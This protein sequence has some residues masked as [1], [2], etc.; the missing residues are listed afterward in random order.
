[1]NQNLDTLP[2]P[3]Q[4]FSEIKLN[5]QISSHVDNSR[6]IIKN[7]LAGRDK[8]LLVVIG[9]CS[10]HDE[11]AC[12]DYA[13]RLKSIKEKYQDSLDSPNKCNFSEGRS[14]AIVGIFLAKG[15]CTMAYTQLTE[16]ER[17]QIFSLKEAG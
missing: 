7:I 4:F 14:V 12:L 11:E 9:P 15:K 3:N 1:M 6:N 8:R 17:Y 16:I 2:I 5:S 13:S 10:V